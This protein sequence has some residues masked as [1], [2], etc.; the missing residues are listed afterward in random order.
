MYDYKSIRNVNIQCDYTVN[1][2]QAFWPSEQNSLGRDVNNNYASPKVLIGSYLLWFTISYDIIELDRR[3]GRML[4][5]ECI[6]KQC[7]KTQ[8]D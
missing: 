5:K 7:Y 8:C 1:T 4:I 3:R 2:G 6:I